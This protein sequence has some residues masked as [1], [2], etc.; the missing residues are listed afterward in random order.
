MNKYSLLLN[1]L[2][3]EYERELQTVAAGTKTEPER[4][5]RY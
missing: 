3:A 1:W 5:L 2:P 4:I